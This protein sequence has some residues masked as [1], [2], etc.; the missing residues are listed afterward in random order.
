MTDVLPASEIV[1]LLPLPQGWYAV[2]YAALADGTLG[3]LG[4]EFD[5]RA[6]RFGSALILGHVA[7]STA[8]PVKTVGDLRSHAAPSM[9]AAGRTALRPGLWRSTPM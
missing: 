2:A 3:I 9:S 5:V 4:S 1:D 7:P 8:C 6:S